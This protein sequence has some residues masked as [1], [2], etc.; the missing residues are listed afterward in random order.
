MTQFFYKGFINSQS[1]YLW[2]YPMLYTYDRVI[3]MAKATPLELPFIE[4]YELFF[5][6]LERE[7]RQGKPE[8]IDNDYILRL[9]ECYRHLYKKANIQ[10]YIR[11]NP[12]LFDDMATITLFQENTTNPLVS[13]FELGLHLEVQFIGYTEDGVFKKHAVK[14]YELAQVLLVFMNTALGYGTAICKT[15]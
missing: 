1:D 10:L 2:D 4:F 5:S 11:F 14:E 7:V 13:I 15:L 12:V 9:S 8:I 6:L 3:Q